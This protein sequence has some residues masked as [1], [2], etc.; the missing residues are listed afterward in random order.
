MV[1]NTDRKLTH[2][3]LLVQSL[4]RMC[5]PAW[6]A[7]LRN[8]VFSKPEIKSEAPAVLF[9]LANIKVA[10]RTLDKDFSTL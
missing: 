1:A 6:E 4:L 10:E 5:F 7:R 9:S 2:C 3:A 8:T